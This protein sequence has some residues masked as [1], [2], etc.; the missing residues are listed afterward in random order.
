MIDNPEIGFNCFS[1][2]VWDTV[3]QKY[4]ALHYGYGAFAG[5]DQSSGDLY[6][7]NFNG[8]QATTNFGIITGFQRVITVKQNGYV[9][10]GTMSPEYMFEVQNSSSACAG[11]F[12]TTV[13]AGDGLVAE[14]DNGIGPYA[15]KGICTNV[16]SG[17]AGYFSGNLHYTGNVIGAFR[18]K[19]ERKHQAF[20]QGTG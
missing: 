14:S 20:K 17:L 3:R 9:G 12:F 10:I 1:S 5:M 16:T 18:S 2:D 13:A 6:I 11:K 8:N 19:T 7:G 15:I 4:T